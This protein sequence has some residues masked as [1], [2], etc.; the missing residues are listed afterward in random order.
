MIGLKVK[1][2]RREATL[3]GYAHEGDA[4]FDLHSCRS[5]DL[6]PEHPT[7]VFPIGLAFEI[8]PGWCMKI[9]S[10]SGHGFNDDVRLA[11]CV[12]IIDQG[13]KGEVM[14]KL[15][16]DD[17]DRG[18]KQVKVGDRIAQAMLERV[19]PVEFV[20]VEEL[21]DTARGAGG[22]GSTGA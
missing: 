2:L 9:Y 4:C 21:S 13:Y 12:G 5:G 14:V 11:N 6:Y 10:R 16:L 20:E 1:R 17:E 7:E 3:P 8:P 18:Y 22:L 15:T 19:E